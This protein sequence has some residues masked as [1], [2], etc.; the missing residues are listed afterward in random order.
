V[1]IQRLNARLDVR[2]ILP[3]V[4]VPTL[5]IYRAGEFVAH[6]E[7]SKYL[8][9]HIAG[10]RFVELEG[11]DYH[12]YVGDQDAILDRVEEFLTGVAPRS[13]G[14]R[15][16][17]TLVLIAPTTNPSA[18]IGDAIVSRIVAE[19]GGHLCTRAGHASLLSFDG[20]SRAITCALAIREALHQAQI[21]AG[22]VAHVGEI[23]WQ[24]KDVRGTAVDQTAALAA[25]ATAGGD[26][27]ISRTLADLI[28][29]SGFA[30]NDM[31]KFDIAGMSEPWR[32]FSVSVEGGGIGPSR[33]ADAGAT[34]A[35]FRREGDT[36]LLGF[37]GRTSRLHASKGL[38]VI[39]TLLADPRREFHVIELVGSAPRMTARMG[40][41]PLLDE[42][43]IREFRERLAE[44][45][46]EVEDAEAMHDQE[47]AATARAEYDTLVTRLSSDLAL[48]GR[49]RPSD[50]WP[51]RARKTIR[52]RLQDALVR[53]EN[54]DPQLGHHLRRSIKTG[55]FCSYD[56]AEP[57]TWIL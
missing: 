8:A 22:I 4:R 13:N 29:G 57:V 24:G 30:C 51:E 11:S 47:R 28:A 44:L 40:A 53:I 27:L 14:D 12:P 56:P 6:V 20:P 52:K 18:E 7:G 50:A 43:A 16:L 48:G 49:S 3:S 1:A 46:D 54:A 26:V 39:A 34:T 37:D 15:V 2:P 42:Q 23:E 5:I 55:A 41:D 25:C 21:E 38:A 9:R 33:A 10:A 36:W 19:F 45:A 17:A 31:G 32:L 35:L